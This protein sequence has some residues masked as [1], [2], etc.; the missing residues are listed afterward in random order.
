MGG[1]RVHQRRR[2]A[3]IGLKPEFLEQGPNP[4][5]FISLRA[6]P[7]SITDET[8]A[9]NPGAAQPLPS[10]NNSGWMKSRP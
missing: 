2:Q 5:P 8:N 10:W 4:I 1:D 3:V 9:A 7:D 6:A